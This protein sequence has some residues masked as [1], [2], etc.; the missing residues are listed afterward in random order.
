MRVDELRPILESRYI[1]T[2]PP[3]EDICR[4][5]NTFILL[6]S[7]INDEQLLVYKYSDADFAFAQ[8]WYSNCVNPVLNW[9][10]IHV[11]IAAAQLMSAGFVQ[12]CRENEKTFHLNGNVTSPTVH[13][14]LWRGQFS[15]M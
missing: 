9:L 7:Y 1:L 3:C 12:D 10:A 15:P 14:E 5:D 2:L 6:S 4:F 8:L 11:Y 13:A